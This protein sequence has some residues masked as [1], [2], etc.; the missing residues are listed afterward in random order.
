[1]RALP[2]LDAVIS[3]GVGFETIDI[4]AAEQLGVVVSN[5]PDVLT[6]CVADLAVGLLID[7][8]RGISAADRFV[9]QGNWINGPYPLG[10]RVSGKRIGIVGLGRIG[11]ATARR[12]EAFGPTIAYHSRN[13]LVEVAY[14]WYE[15]LID[16]A[17]D[18]DV[19][20]VAV[21]GGTST[22]GLVSREVIAALG[23]DGYLINVARGTVVDE[24]A[25]VD[26]LAQ[27]QIAGA[28]LDVYTHEPRVPEALLALDNVVA[29]PHLG[30]ATTETRLDMA[31]LFLMN[32]R[33]FIA[34]GTL[35]TPVS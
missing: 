30:S 2:N 27:K 15:S 5:T 24:N 33:Q 8:L 14:P 21:S 18:S 29:L 35:T 6:D 3:F 20:I 23:S 26:A 16:L 17:S 28:G 11:L 19:L 10:T 32:L 34:E 13:R 9:R 22:T 25:L 31:N 12:L 4:C 7:C 1:M